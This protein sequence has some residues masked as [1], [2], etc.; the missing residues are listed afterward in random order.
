MP[1][2]VFLPKWGLTMTEATILHWLKQEGDSVAAD[3]E[4]VEVETDKVVNTL[5]APVAGV[6]SQILVKEQ[7]TVEVGTELAVITPAG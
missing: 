4:L 5:T 6:L 3:E 2:S 1:E 7:E